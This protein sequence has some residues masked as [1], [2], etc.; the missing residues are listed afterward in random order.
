MAIGIRKI[1]PFKINSKTETSLVKAGL[2]GAADGIACAKVSTCNC[3]NVL[4]IFIYF[5]AIN[6]EN[7]F[8][9]VFH[10]YASQYKRKKIQK[11]ITFG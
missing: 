3:K 1:P 9:F 7:N 2:V 6:S 11:S 5:L 4:I 8:N 10:E